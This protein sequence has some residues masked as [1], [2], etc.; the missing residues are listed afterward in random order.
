MIIACH[1]FDIMLS[2]RYH[3][4]LGVIYVYISLDESSSYSVVKNYSYNSFIST[5]NCTFK[6]GCNIFET[7]PTYERME[8]KIASLSK[9]P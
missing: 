7:D 2:V 9:K 5:G 1:P 6:K 3:H 8:L 4:N